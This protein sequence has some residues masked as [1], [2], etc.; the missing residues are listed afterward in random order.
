MIHTNPHFLKNS[1]TFCVSDRISE[2]VRVAKMND[3]FKNS[4]DLCYVAGRRMTATE[5]VLEFQFDFF[6]IHAW[7][8]CSLGVHKAW[9]LVVAKDVFGHFSSDKSSH[10][11]VGKVGIGASDSL[12][13]SAT[14]DGMVSQAF[15]ET[16]LLWTNWFSIY[17][18]KYIPHGQGSW[19][20]R[21][22]AG[23]TLLINVSCQMCVVV[24]S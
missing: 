10:S 19:N 14:V 13:G 7:S 20:V 17:T 22:D 11:S 24:F 15:T 23:R 9:N 4:R 5:A 8:P 12:H 2:S 3:T 6:A 16:K 21:F 18:F 1:S